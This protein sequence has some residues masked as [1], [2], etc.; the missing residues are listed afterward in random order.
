MDLMF[1]DRMQ[2]FAFSTDAIS[3]LP[4]EALLASIEV[5]STLSSTELN[6][7]VAAARAFKACGDEHLI[8]A[9]YVR[10]RG[11]INLTHKIARLEDEDGGA[12]AAFYFSMLNFIQREGARRRA[13]PYERYT[14]PPQWRIDQTFSESDTLALPCGKH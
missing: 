9:I 6:K 3:V 2:N 14:D 13:T 1:Y 12:V 5:K 7:S 11:L 8:D 10:N 4:A